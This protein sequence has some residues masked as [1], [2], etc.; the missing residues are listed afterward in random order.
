[1]R[2]C[3]Q[4][5]KTTG[6][7]EQIN[8]AWPKTVSHEPSGD[9][10]N[11]L[12]A[13]ISISGCPPLNWGFNA[14]FLIHQVSSQEI[15]DPNVWN[16]QNMFHLAILRIYMFDVKIWLFLEYQHRGLREHH[17][18]ERE[19]T[20]L[21]YHP[22]EFAKCQFIV[23]SVSRLLINLFDNKGWDWLMRLNLIMIYSSCISW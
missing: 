23:V 9:K 6:L 19:N 4:M 7:V 3:D 22:E 16:L 11:W 8:A 13:S 2:A 20:W 18:H 5:L 14:A 15:C 10:T 12:P 1:M 21:F 17:S